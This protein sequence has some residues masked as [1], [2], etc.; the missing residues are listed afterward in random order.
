MNVLS[1]CVQDIVK[2]WHECKGMII[3]VAI[4]ICIGAFGNRIHCRKKGVVCLPE[5]IFFYRLFIWICNGAYFVYSIYITFGM[6]YVGMR[7]EVEWIP[8]VGVWKRPW[9]YPLLVENVLLFIEQYKTS[10]FFF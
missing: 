7:R 1:R 8:F 9:E 5:S 10:Y 3:F 6:R 2:Y 4:V